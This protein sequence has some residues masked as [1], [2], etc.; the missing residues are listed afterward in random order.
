M[1][2]YEHRGGDDW[3]PVGDAMLDIT[4]LVM[5]NTEVKDNIYRFCETVHGPSKT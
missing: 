2:D 5:A 1:L 4:R 3:L